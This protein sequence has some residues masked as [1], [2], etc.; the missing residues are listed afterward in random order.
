MGPICNLT[1]F[2]AFGIPSIDRDGRDLFLVVCAARFRLPSPGQGPTEAL[3]PTAEQPDPCIG[4]RYRG[5]PGSTSLLEEGQTAFSRP[6]TDITCVGV[7]R[8]TGAVAVEALPVGFA[9]GPCRVQARVLGE[10]VWD[11]GAG[12]GLRLSRPR[13]FVTMPLTWERAFG[14]CARDAEGALMAQDPRNPVGRGFCENPAALLGSLAPNIEDPQAPIALPS[15][16][17]EPIGFGPVARSWPAR[18]RFAGTYDDA[19]CRDRAPLWP[20]DF[21]E[22]F[23]CAAPPALQATPHLRGGEPV[24]LQ[25]FHSAGLVQF[26]LPTLRLRARFRFDGHDV[27][28]PMVLDGVQF[29]T[30]AWSVTLVFRA[31][32]L[33]Q[34][35]IAS[36]RE[37]IVRRLADWE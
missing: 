37:T 28:L 11:R 15:D 16:R 34:A 14:G 29:D 21:D 30:E 12:G 4:D 18:R 31:A 2:G 10:R 25:G 22:R 9:V 26:R 13:P 23:F 27:R 32:A 17:P 19:W 20:K 8:A 24:A 1:G 6:A 5:S 35:G 3:E 36:H 33:A 7:A